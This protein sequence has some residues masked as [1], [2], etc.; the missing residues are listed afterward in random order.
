R[1]W[2]VAIGSNRFVVNLGNCCLNEIDVPSPLTI[3]TWTQLA[4]TFDY[5]MNDATLFSNGQALA[6]ALIIDRPSPTWPLRFCGLASDFGQSVFLNGL[7][8]EVHVFN[9]VLTSS[10][11]QA[12]ATPVIFT[13]FFPPISN[14]PVVNVVQAGQAIPVTFSLG[15]NQGLTIFAPGYP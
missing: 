1:L 15:G 5:S 12:L 10:E 4:L 3:G 9:R 2:L 8:D 7:L 13:G 14:V 6:S 11:I